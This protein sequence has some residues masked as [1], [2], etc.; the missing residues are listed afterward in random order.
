MNDVTLHN[1][2]WATQTHIHNSS[3]PHTHTHTHT[4]LCLMPSKWCRLYWLCSGCKLTEWWNCSP[5][6][7][8]KGDTNLWE[9][10]QQP[11]GVEWNTISV[12]FKYTYPHIHTPIPTS[13]THTQMCNTHTDLR[14]YWLE[15]RML[16]DRWSCSTGHMGRER[17]NLW[18]NQ[19]IEY[20][21]K[22]A[23]HAGACFVHRH[24]KTCVQI[25]ILA[26][27]THEISQLICH[28][29]MKPYIKGKIL[30]T[31][32]STTNAGALGS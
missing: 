17:T 5:E 20:W 28:C 14:Y 23:I 8:G 10:L 27:T 18:S 13:H 11:L 15:C 16:R 30:Y 2:H 12:L 1:L 32:P 21:E 22:S 3:L 7:I 31:D 9:N 24:K 29:M 6:H 19:H 26:L 25:H 4:D